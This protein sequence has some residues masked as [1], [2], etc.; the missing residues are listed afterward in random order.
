MDNFSDKCMRWPFR[1]PDGEDTSEIRGGSS[2]RGEVGVSSPGLLSSFFRSTL[3]K[4][5]N[6]HRVRCFL[7]IN[8]INF[9]RHLVTRLLPEEEEDVPGDISSRAP[10]YRRQIEL[11]GLKT[12]PALQCKV[13]G[14]Q[15]GPNCVKFVKYGREQFGNH[16]VTISKTGQCLMRGPKSKEKQEVT[17]TSKEQS[18]V[19]SPA[20]IRRCRQFCREI[21][22][23][24]FCWLKNSFGNL[25]DRKF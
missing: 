18:I 11:S 19:L 5:Q 25:S 7:R 21:L 3:N 2:D 14:G 9:K 22:V 6:S 10:I 23:N 8:W 1:T 16:N 13:P 15:T 20:R 4:S 24:I 17:G 12:K